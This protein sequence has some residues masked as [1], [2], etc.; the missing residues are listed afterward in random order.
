MMFLLI[1][2]FYRNTTFVTEKQQMLLGVQH[3]IVGLELGL[4]K[5]M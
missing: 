1:Q 3:V 2:K 4:F 5:A